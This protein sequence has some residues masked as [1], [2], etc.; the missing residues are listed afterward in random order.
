MSTA[1]AAVEEVAAPTSRKPDARVAPVPRAG[2]APL[3]P[4]APLVL[5]ARADAMGSEAL[6]S[7]SGSSNSPGAN[8]SV[9]I[10]PESAGAGGTD[11]LAVG[12]VVKPDEASG[13]SGL[14]SSS[15]PC[16]SKSSS[17]SIGPFDGAVAG[18]AGVAADE[19]ERAPPTCGA[20]PLNP[21]GS[22]TGRSAKGSKADREA[23]SIVFE[24]DSGRSI[25]NVSCSLAAEVPRRW[26]TNRPAS[27]GFVTPVTFHGPI[28]TVPAL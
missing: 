5:S 26:L 9:G 3:E 11:V 19:E 25:L 23:A 20:V 17:E 4:P 14:M 8:I 22:S 18:D 28:F 12:Q 13:A 10:S 6:S 15:T 16:A 21:S 2:T 27:V 24:P 1:E 7:T